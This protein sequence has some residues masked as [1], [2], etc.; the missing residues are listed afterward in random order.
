MVGGFVYSVAS[1]TVGQARMIKNIDIPI[2]GADVTVGTFTLVMV[3]RCVWH[4]AT[5]TFCYADVVKAGGIL[6]NIGVEVA[7]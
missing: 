2:I 7:T 5:G 6:P 4:M 3:G 1:H